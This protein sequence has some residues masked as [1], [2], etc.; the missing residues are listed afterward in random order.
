LVC[1]FV[2]GYIDLCGGVVWC[3]GGGIV[4]VLGVD[5]LGVVK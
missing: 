3:G 2:I 1:L 4:C 5:V